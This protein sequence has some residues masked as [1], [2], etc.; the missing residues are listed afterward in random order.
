MMFAV[1]AV[2]NAFLRQ[3]KNIEIV[4]PLAAKQLVDIGGWKFLSEHGD[5]TKAWMG[6]P[7]YG[8]ERARAREAV[9]RMR[10]DLGFDYISIGHWHVPGIVSG[11]I[12]IN[13]SLSGTSEYD[14]IAGRHALPAQ[15][16]FL[17]HKKYGLFNWVAWTMK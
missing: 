10:T 1:Y 7:F 13:G 5:T 12:L 6:I 16:S 2:T 14:H 3:H 11:N 17:V 4:Q 8:I 15:V 9:R